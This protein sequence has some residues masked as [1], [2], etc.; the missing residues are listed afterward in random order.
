MKDE[1]SEIM[2][3]ITENTEIAE[4]DTKAAETKEANLK[5]ESELI[6]I[7]KA[8]AD[9]EYAAAKPALEAAQNA[10][11]K[12]SNNDLTE[13]K[14]NQRP[15]PVVETVFKCGYYLW[16]DKGKGHDLDTDD[17]A[18]ARNDFLCAN[19]LLDQ[20][21]K[22][23]IPKLRQ[24][25]VNK[26]NQALTKI[27]KES[28][29]KIETDKEKIIERVSSASKAAGGIFRWILATLECYEIYKKVKPL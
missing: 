23:P 13:A 14:T 4:R 6:T 5:V 9:E 15:V 10:L 1:V 19:Q 11:T 21:K 25:A 7:K 12:I 20:L 17:Y 22:Y 8:Q 27:E 29:N 28:G 16:L 2:K 18:I 24:P 3:E 26:V